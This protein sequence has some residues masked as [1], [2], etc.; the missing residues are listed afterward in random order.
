MITEGEIFYI[1][2]RLSGKQVDVCHSGT[3]NGTN[4]HLWTLNKT[5]IHE[6]RILKN[7]G[8]YSFLSLCNES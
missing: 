1:Q 5:N 6:L 3:D 7:G 8:Y 2:S 4:I